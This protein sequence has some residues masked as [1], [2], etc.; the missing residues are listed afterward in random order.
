L[1]PRFAGSNPAEDDEYLRA[2]KIRSVTS[3]G[4]EVKPLTHVARFYG[5]LKKPVGY[6]R[7]IRRQNS[8]QF[9]AKFLLLS[10]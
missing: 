8:Q 9:L 1:E 6:E 5:M 7:D 2:I 4:V 10:Y 3:F